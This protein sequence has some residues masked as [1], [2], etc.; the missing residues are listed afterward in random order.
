MGG[1]YLRRRLKHDGT[2]E[3]APMLPHERESRAASLG[4][5]DVSAQP[6]AGATVLIPDVMLR[7]QERDFL[8]DIAWD[9]LAS[10]FPDANLKCVPTDGRALV[11]Y[12]L[13]EVGD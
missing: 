3:C 8:D 11:R 9:E 12:T 4:L 7:Q 13:A 2:P 1:V 5:V 6:V 10:A